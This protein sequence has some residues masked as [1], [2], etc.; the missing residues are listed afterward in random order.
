MPTILIIDDSPIDRELARSILA[1]EDSLTVEIVED[2]RAGLARLKE[3]GVDLVLTDLVMPE[4]N[5]LQ[6]VTTIRIDYPEVP[7]ILMTSQGTDVIA[8]DALEQGAAGYVPKRML[9]EWLVDTVQ[10]VLSV[11]SAGQAYHE[12]AAS[13]NSTQF[14]LTLQNDA[15]LFDPLVDYVQQMAIGIQ[16]VDPNGGYRLG[17]AFREALNNSLYRGNLELSR[18]QMSEESERLVTGGPSLVEQRRNEDPYRERKLDVAVRIT[19]HEVEIIITDKGPGFDVAA[20][21]PTD[22]S[23]TLEDAP[24]R[25]LVLMRTLVDEVSFNETG[26]EVTLRCKRSESD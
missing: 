21:S 7:V 1:E 4:V 26:N 15:A 10:D 8:V 12:L 11:A 22:K 19:R 25:G 3:G 9:N 18:E 5:G 20:V 24:G 16:V 23:T 2:G 17:V 6:V 13:F 14:D